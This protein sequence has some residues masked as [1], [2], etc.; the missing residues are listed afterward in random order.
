MRFLVDIMYL[1]ALV[2]TSPVWVYRMLRH[3]RYRSGP[4]ER[5]LGSVPV[6]YGRQ[7]II[8][9]HGVSLGEVNAARMLVAELHRQLPDYQVVISSTTDTGMTAARKLFTPD[10]WVFQWPIDFSWAVGRA[11]NRLRPSL[12]VLMEGEAWPNFLSACK[13]RKIPAAIVNGRLG[14]TKGY[15]RYK[16]MGPLARS[17]FGKL[18]AVGAQTEEYAEMFRSLGVPAEGACV[19]GMLKYDTAELDR[20][21][22]DKATLASALGLYS[23]S[24][25]VVAGGTGDGEEAQLLTHWPAIRAAHPNARLAIVPRKPERFD[26]VARLIAK[27]GF[28]V[29]RRSDATP[30]MTHNADAIILGDTMGELKTFYALAEVVFVGRSLASMG[31]SDMIEAAALGKPTAFGPHTYNFPQADDL[32]AHGC[33]RVADVSELASVLSGWLADPTSA[34]VAG[35]NAQEYVISQ[36]GATKRNVDMLCGFLGRAPAIAEGTISTD[37]IDS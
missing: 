35:K 25:L 10:H 18:T 5:L 22:A 12:V 21:E 33:V 20:P 16:K 37:A 27:A 31:G 3:G 14:A 2:G 9:I 7:P 4:A 23:D 26:E 32:V 15:P 1:L 29:L 24:R 17:L 34:S 6:R 28:T 19:T 13:R 36:Q 8:W 11:L 30:E